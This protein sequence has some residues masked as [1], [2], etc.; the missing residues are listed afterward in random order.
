[1]HVTDRKFSKEVRNGR[2]SRTANVRASWPKK[3]SLQVP[4]D[5]NTT[6]AVPHLAFSVKLESC[7]WYKLKICTPWLPLLDSYWMLV[8][9]SMNENAPC[10]SS[11]SWK[12]S[13]IINF[14]SYLA[15][16]LT[17]F[18]MRF[19]GVDPTCGQINGW[20]VPSCFYIVAMV[21]QSAACIWQFVWHM[22]CWSDMHCF[23]LWLFQLNS[24]PLP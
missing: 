24:H 8:C 20:W 5:S 19:C 7:L 2:L 1:M 23:L 4:Y 14:D 22:H 16:S 18:D 9:L 12:L 17:K 3:I 13:F 15:A 6:S 11:S 21:F 10:H